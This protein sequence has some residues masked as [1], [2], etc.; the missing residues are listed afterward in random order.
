MFT[1][2][3]TSINWIPLTISKIFRYLSSE[4]RDKR[5]IIR[6]RVANSNDVIN[7]THTFSTG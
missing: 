1:P 4:K 3:E 7:D 5:K 6:Q 2:R